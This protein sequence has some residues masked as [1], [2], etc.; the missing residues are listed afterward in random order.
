M[1]EFMTQLTENQNAA[2]GNPRPGHPTM[3]TPAGAP[4]ASPTTV[5]PL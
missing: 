4:A 3:N 5:P 1:S 2:A